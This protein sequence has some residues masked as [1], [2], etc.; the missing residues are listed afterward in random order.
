MDREWQRLLALY[1]DKADEELLELQERR[2]DLTELA[3]QA[4]D[5]VMKERGLEAEVLET[6]GDALPDDEA[7]VLGQPYRVNADEINLYY[8]NDPIR[9]SIARDLLNSESVVHRMVVQESSKRDGMR[10]SYNASVTL[11]VPNDQQERARELLERE[12]ALIFDEGPVAAQEM[13]DDT[14]LGM[15]TKAQAVIIT[16][17]LAE[18]GISCSTDDSPREQTPVLISVP[19][20][21]LEEAFELMEEIAETL[22]GED[23]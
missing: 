3:Q 17:A 9:A 21:Q 20:E 14:V 18:R 5:R 15:F 4:L 19:A 23:E 10:G 22:P 6:D 1:A 16:N 13:E 7:I 2:D 11:I 8:F 12:M